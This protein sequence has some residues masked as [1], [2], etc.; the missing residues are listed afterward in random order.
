V[1]T[2]RLLPGRHASEIDPLILSQTRTTI[3]FLIL[4]P[5]L[6]VLRGRRLF[7]FRRG[8]WIKC[9]LIGAAGISASNYFYYVAIQRTTIA[10]GITLQYLAP[11]VVLFYMVALH[12]QRPTV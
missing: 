5:V 7:T 9:L 10:I 6:L 11:I 4:L 8:D 3:G 1:F 12:R 2:G